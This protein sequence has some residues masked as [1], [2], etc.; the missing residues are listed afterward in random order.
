[1][2][3]SATTIVTAVGAL[4]GAL[5]VQVVGVLEVAVDMMVVV[6]VMVIA[7]ER[8]GVDLGLLK[9]IKCGLL[10]WYV[11]ILTYREVGAHPKHVENLCR[12]DLGLGWDRGSWEHRVPILLEVMTFKVIRYILLTMGGMCLI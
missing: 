5:Q 1:M 10:P 2:V 8:G 11:L 3:V 4:S 12:V 6:M 7:V 9:S